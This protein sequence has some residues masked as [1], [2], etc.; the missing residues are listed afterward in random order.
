L[1]QG[2]HA[3][4]AQAFEGKAM[5]TIR[6][7]L[8]AALVCAAAAC[9][10]TSGI[11]V[12][13]FVRP[14]NY[15]IDDAARD[16]VHQF[17]KGKIQITEDSTG[18]LASLWKSLNPWIKTFRYSLDM[19]ICQHE[20]CG[21]RN[22]NAVANPDL[23]GIPETYFLHFA[24][25]TQIR[26]RPIS[27][28]PLDYGASDPWIV[29]IPGCPVGTPVRRECRVQLWAWEDTYFF[30]HQGSP[31]FG[32][33]MAQRLLSLAR[34]LGD[35]GIFLDAHGPGFRSIYL[36]STD[37]LS[38]GLVRE[39]AKRATDPAIDDPYNAQLVS[40][41]ATEKTA[42]NADGHFLLVNCAAW[43]LDPHCR[44]QAVAAGG[45]HTEMLFITTMSA[46][47]IDDLI[48]LIGEISSRSYGIVD[49]YGSACWWGGPTYTSRGNFSSARARYLYWRFA[50]YQLVREDVAPGHAYFD[51]T[52]CFADP[53]GNG[54]D[55]DPTRPGVY[56]DYQ[57]EW[58]GA[59]TGLGAPL[60]QAY[61]FVE[62]NSPPGTCAQ[63]WGRRYTVF[64]REFA[65]GIVLVRPRDSWDCD[66]YGDNSS[67]MLALDRQYRLRHDDG[68]LGPPIKQ[69]QIRNAEAVILERL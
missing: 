6:L 34:S 40:N 32:G 65:D 13:E 28:S 8:V 49:L 19:A 44:A 10:A 4:S 23:A 42:L 41:L 46:D 3:G 54:T 9:A 16:R 52:L 5:R 51:P 67:V 20:G 37:V 27:G 69:I 45:L 22:G 66:G 30:F 12:L 21:Y 47:Q 39:L 63:N 68:T 14:G 35:D 1:E 53:W 57:S 59:F 25:T 26:L 17:L 15:Y 60:G 62:G 56:D 43:S 24:E 64:K 7:V 18:T 48:G 38:G 61:R 11:F 50:A 55:F 58:L 31:G 36:S 2:R 33:W 29:T